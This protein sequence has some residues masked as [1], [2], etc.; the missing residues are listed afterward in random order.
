MYEARQNKEKVSRRIDGGSMAR[1]RVQLR[2]MR[3]AQRQTRID[4]TTQVL[5][6]AGAGNW[7]VGKRMN[8]LL[9]PND[10]VIGSATNQK[11]QKGLIDKLGDDYCKGHLLNHDLGGLAIAANLFPITHEM[12]TQHN[13]MAEEPVKHSLYA[14]NTVY[15]TVEATNQNTNFNSIDEFKEGNYGFKWGARNNGYP[16]PDKLHNRQIRRDNPVNDFYRE[17]WSHYRDGKERKGLSPRSSPDI[18]SDTLRHSSI[19]NMRLPLNPQI[20]SKH[21]YYS[22]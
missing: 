15:Y 19:D 17:Q 20:M 6:I 9:D 7:I 12:N 16:Y 8:A 22:G 5:H 14:G 2:N 18:T 10:S 4:Y 1:Q 13:N 21:P 11:V 3:I